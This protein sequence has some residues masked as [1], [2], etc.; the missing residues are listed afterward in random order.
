M[1]SLM[2]SENQ[3]IKASLKIKS[4]MN[5]IPLIQSGE[6]SPVFIVDGDSCIVSLNS[7]ALG[8]RDAEYYIG[9]DIHSHI[10]ETNASLNTQKVFFRNSWYDLRSESIR[11]NNEECTKMVFTEEKGY[12][13]LDELKNVQRMSEVLV[14][15]VRSPL[16]G[17]QGYLDMVLE[18]EE[19]L[20]QESKHR[21]QKVDKGIQY[22]FDMMDN[23][24][25]IY[26]LNITREE[27][28]TES[29]D[30]INVT[31]ELLNNYTEEIQKKIEITIQEDANIFQADRTTLSSVL[32][33][34]LSNALE[35]S[36]NE[37]NSVKIQF[38]SAY[39][40]SVTNRGN[41]IEDERVNDLFRP[42]VTSK[43]DRM[44]LGLT[45]AYMYA[46][47]SNGTIYLSSNKT[48]EIT[49]TFSVAPKEYLQ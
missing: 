46:Q 39:Q 4:D 19:G 18:G 48:D 40:V 22:L 33:V 23:L 31:T 6:H 7:A 2:E 17:M 26:D 5:L 43:A 20:K 45:L 8:S 30:A 21:L 27:F 16:T 24:K 9:T 13:S 44:G 41:R 35:H 11:F 3:C 14:H 38:D 29:V 1:L 34:L 10:F 25:Q 36:R 42:F 15:R 49:F 12:P 37:E 28:L 32:H 47:Q